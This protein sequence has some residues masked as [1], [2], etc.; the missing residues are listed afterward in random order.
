MLRFVLPPCVCHSVPLNVLQ[1]YKRI[2]RLEQAMEQQRLEYIAQVKR[3]RAKYGGYKRKARQYDETMSQR[4]V[5]VWS[6]WACDTLIT[7]HCS[8]Q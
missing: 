8:H 1:L 4:Q 7:L 6:A 2:S 3:L 5:G